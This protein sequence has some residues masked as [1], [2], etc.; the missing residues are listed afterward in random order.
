MLHELR[1]PFNAIIGFSEVLSEEMFGEV[2]EKQE[3]YLGDILSSGP[4]LLSLIND[5]MDLS[6]V[7]A[8]QMFSAALQTCPVWGSARA[9]GGS[10]S[11]RSR[12]ATPILLSAI[13]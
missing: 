5:S 4:H 7:E 13:P 11:G 3:E 8:G 9:S 6:K 2:N 12:R 1:T 10:C